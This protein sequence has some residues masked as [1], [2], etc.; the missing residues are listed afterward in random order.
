MEGSQASSDVTSSSSCASLFMESS[1]LVV[2]RGII[3]DG[4]TPEFD[5]AQRHPALSCRPSSQTSWWQ[6]RRRD[7]SACRSDTTCWY[8]VARQFS[9]AGTPPGRGLRIA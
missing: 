8:G 9:R 7:P 4:L 2:L 3:Q 5:L 1:P 6:E